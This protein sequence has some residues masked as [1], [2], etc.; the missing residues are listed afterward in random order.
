MWKPFPK[1]FMGCPFLGEWNSGYGKLS[2]MASEFPSVIY[3]WLSTLQ[4]SQY[5]VGLYQ[6]SF[7]VLIL[8]VTANRTLTSS[9][10]ADLH[11]LQTFV[12]PRLLQ[13]QCL[14]DK[15][16]MRLSYGPQCT[17]KT[18]L[19][20]KKYQDYNFSRCGLQNPLIVTLCDFWL[21]G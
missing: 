15:I 4:N 3:K 11:L 16:F 18:Y 5:G 21:S 19:K 6:V 7:S 20:K 1:H 10:T 14:S 9:I 8:K 12:I 2:N 13:K 17:T